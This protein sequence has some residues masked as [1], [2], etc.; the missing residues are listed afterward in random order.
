MRAY[1]TTNTSLEIVLWEFP[2]PIAAILAVP[3]LYI[4]SRHPDVA[5][6]AV[7]WAA[8]VVSRGEKNEILLMT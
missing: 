1:A 7:A 2:D 5:D 3:H 4:N 8:E 6:S